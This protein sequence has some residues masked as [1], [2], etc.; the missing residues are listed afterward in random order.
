MND[1]ARLVSSERSELAALL[2]RRAAEAEAS[3]SIESG[4]RRL[5][6]AYL[7]S[8][9]GH[10]TSD[11]SKRP[12]QASEVRALV[13]ALI[14]RLPI[15]PAIAMLLSTTYGRFGLLECEL[16]SLAAELRSDDSARQAEVRQ[17]LTE[18]RDRE[19]ESGEGVF[20]ALLHTEESETR[21]VDLLLR[22]RVSA[23]YAGAIEEFVS[24]VDAAIAAIDP[25]S[26]ERI[27]ELKR[28]RA[29]A[30][31]SDPADQG[32]AAQA[33]RDL[34]D[35]FEREDDLRDFEAF[36][37]S[38]PSAEERH[39]ERRWIYGWRAARAP[40]PA[41]ILVSWAA[42]E[43][44]YGDPD[45]AIDVYQRLAD[46]DLH[47]TDALEALCRLKLDTGDYEGALRPL[48]AL[49]ALG[50]ETGQR[51]IGLGIA[52]LLLDELARPR[53]AIEILVPLLGVAPP[54]L[55]A[56][57][58]GRRLIADSA[59]QEQVLERFV[60]VANEQSPLESLRAFLF[61]VEA[62]EETRTLEQRR[63]WLERIAVL[64]PA[65]PAAAL[66]ALVQGAQE[67]T[68]AFALWD[69]AERI[70]RDLGCADLVSLAYYNVLVDGSVTPAV[71]ETIGRR[72]VHFEGDCATESSRVIDALQRVLELVPEARWAL[73]RVKLVLGSQGRWDELFQL[74]DRA[75]SAA[76]TDRERTEWLEEAA[77][78]AKDLAVDPA[79]A[80]QYLELGHTL[81]PDD[82]ATHAALERLYERQGRTRDLIELLGE[83]VETSSGFQLRQLRKR[84]AEL[85]LDLGSAKD[86]IDVVERGTGDD[87][88]VADMVDVLERLAARPAGEG[89]DAART[90]APDDRAA[91]E[92]A[93]ELLR[94]HYRRAGRMGDVVRLAEARLAL[95]EDDAERARF[96][97]DLLDLCLTAS[98]GPSAFARVFER[99]HAYVG[100]K[101]ALAKIAY[102]WLLVRALRAW[103]R[104]APEEPAARDAES[105]ALAA[106]DHL[107]HLFAQASEARAGCRLLHRGSRMPFAHPQR[108]ELLAE[109]AFVASSQE[110]LRKTAIR[111]F[112]E[113]FDADAGDN[114]AARSLDPLAELL[115]A[116]GEH[117]RL[118]SLLEEQARLRERAGRRR[119]ACAFWERA[120]GMWS[121]EGERERA[122]GAYRQGAELGS[123]ASFEALARIHE[124]AGEWADAANALRWLY[125]HADGAA[126]GPTALRMSEAYGAMGER[127]HAR[128]C[129]EEALAKGGANVVAAR[130]ITLYRQDAIWP[131][132]ADLLAAEAARSQDRPRKLAMLREAADIQRG[133]LA[134][135]AR[136]AALLA[137]AIGD[138]PDDSG[139]R[140]ALADVLEVLERWA[141][142]ADV[143]RDQIARCADVRSKERALLHQRRAR[144]LVRAGG[145]WTRWSSCASPPTWSRGSPRFFT[146][147][148]ASHSISESSSWP[149]APSACSFLRSITPAPKPRS[150]RAARASSSI[151]AKSRCAVAR[152]CG[153]RI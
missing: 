64:A 38:R 118:A 62:R 108:R 120:A 83:R 144:A 84:I 47:R 105:G 104:A 150:S 48:R 21:R 55:G 70:A 121:G 136:A 23:V 114:A 74:Y 18:L 138:N 3:T 139:L 56:H 140:P 35:A 134:N 119:D 67:Q 43:E 75:I 25:E 5:L 41:A 28:A 33:Y 27:R 11:D 124:E 123:E 126:R 20:R 107:K 143:L 58:M 93:I 66:P 92:R 78:A 86:A 129:L 141:D 6:C 96:I 17:R 132:L 82:T 10:T 14:E 106:I 109:A 50:D 128:T 60:E 147:W 101:P 116:A 103:R 135:P 133:P 45:A 7:D 54:L 89:P 95:A 81:Q 79:R 110:D 145:R 130:L 8:L 51:A 94:V 59:A 85:W 97:R 24:L 91:A 30:L 49:R 142:A 13:D 26:R 87:A 15:D 37:E 122:I 31:A 32:Q 16:A 90:A 112:G 111:F 125:A 72:M 152:R 36:V 98:V 39:H 19:S 100:G 42:A 73:D 137:I 4:R 68:D 63:A 77:F 149:K 148:R 115:M 151:S 53:D 2:E 113:L 117:I 131:S 65:D 80:I 69:A 34:L 71:A 127:E 40:H 12:G 153:G 1:E 61:L 57:E 99:A 102:R 44:E 22:L 146:I 9:R 46:L 88:S 76:R 52:R 29:E